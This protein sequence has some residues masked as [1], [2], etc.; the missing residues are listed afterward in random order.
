MKAFAVRRRSSQPR[1]WSSEPS[2]DVVGPFTG[3]VHRLR[4]GPLRVPRNNIEARALGDDL[5]GDHI[6]DNQAGMVIDDGGLRGSVT[7]ARS[8]DDRSRCGRFDVRD[9]GR[10]SGRRRYRGGQLY[11]RRWSAGDRGRWSVRG[12]QRSSTNRMS[13]RTG[14]PGAAPRECCRSWSTPTDDASSCRRCRSISTP[15][16]NGGYDATDPRWAHHAG[17]RDRGSVSRAGLG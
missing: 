9:P 10:R 14:T 2:D 7:D 12:G 4:G 15:D 16:G 8:R 6:I 13:R 5:D 3:P 17:A 1:A 11:R